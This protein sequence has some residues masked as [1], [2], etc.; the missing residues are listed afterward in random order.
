MDSIFMVMDYVEHDLKSLM[1]ELKKKK[2]SFMP[3]LNMFSSPHQ[4]QPSQSF[5]R[6]LVNI[7]L[8]SRC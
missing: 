8:I 3:G 6:H 4:N 2:H 1:E 5:A 7:D